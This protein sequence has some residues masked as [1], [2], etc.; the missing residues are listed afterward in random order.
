[1]R[2][3]PAGAPVDK[4]ELPRSGKRPAALSVLEIEDRLEEAALTLRR[5]PNPAGTGPKGYGSS[6]PEYVRE[7]RHAYGY[8]AARMRVI[9][10][11]REISRM[12]EAIGWLALIE[13]PDDRRLVWLRAEG[14]RWRG[15]CRVLGISRATAWRRWSAALLTISKVLANNEKQPLSGAR[16]KISAG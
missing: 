1:M 14:Q 6:W 13:A 4:S 5:L 11:P 8:H 2:D 15:V 7:T 16:G 12:D 9:P 3:D 10:N